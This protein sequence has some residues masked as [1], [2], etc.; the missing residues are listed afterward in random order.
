MDEE[1]FHALHTTS[2]YLLAQVFKNLKMK[3]QSTLLCYLTLNRQ[4]GRCFE[5]TFPRLYF[6]GVFK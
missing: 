1:T 4:G 3:Q 5:G 6:F 2:L